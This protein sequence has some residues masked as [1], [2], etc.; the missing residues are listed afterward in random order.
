MC[1]I[2]YMKFIYAREAHKSTCELING[3]RKI[4]KTFGEKNIITYLLS[5]L[6][7]KINSGWNEL[8]NVKKET[9]KH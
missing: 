6:N 9:S 7:V 3:I 2:I 1:V 5:V 8:P 4:G